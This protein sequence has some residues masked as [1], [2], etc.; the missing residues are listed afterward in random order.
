MGRSQQSLSELQIAR[1]VKDGRGQGVGK[2]YTP[3]LSR[4]V[5]VVVLSSFH[6][7]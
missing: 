3:W 2:N 6:S 4:R 1:R 5:R 7:S